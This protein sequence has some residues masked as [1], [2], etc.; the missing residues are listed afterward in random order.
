MAQ[1]FRDPL[2]W[3]AQKYLSNLES[4]YGTGYIKVVGKLGGF[5]DLKQEAKANPQDK[6]I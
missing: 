4:K 3:R 5:G 2:S 6:Q 1:H